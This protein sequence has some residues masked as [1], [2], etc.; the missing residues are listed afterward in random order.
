MNGDVSDERPSDE[1]DVDS[2]KDDEGAVGQSSEKARLNQRKRNRRQSWVGASM[3]PMQV[4][5]VEKCTRPSNR[6]MY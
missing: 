5:S 2:E 1:D 6:L 4:L 3:N